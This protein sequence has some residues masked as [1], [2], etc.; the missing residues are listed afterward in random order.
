MYKKYITP[1][2]KNQMLKLAF[3][4]N[5]GNTFRYLALGGEN[6][7]AANQN[8]KSAFTEISGDNY[9]RVTLNTEDTVQNQSIILSGIFED[10]NFNPS[11]GRLI[12]EIGIVD[13][14]VHKDDETF[15]A[16]AEVPEIYKNSSISLKYTVIITLH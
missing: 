7:S 8:S 14:S 13:S 3:L 4:S 1:E 2:G 6:S 9:Q 10:S 5:Q 12:K 16:F 11:N 15:F